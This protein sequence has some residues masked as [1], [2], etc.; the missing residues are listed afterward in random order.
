MFDTTANELAPLEL[1][2]MDDT[3]SAGDLIGR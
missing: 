2:V 3:S 1:M